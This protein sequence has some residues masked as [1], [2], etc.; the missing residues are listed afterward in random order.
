LATRTPVKKHPGE[1]MEDR[2]VIWDSKQDFTKGKSCLTNLV[3]F[4]D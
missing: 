2:E 4:Y 3:A 1:H